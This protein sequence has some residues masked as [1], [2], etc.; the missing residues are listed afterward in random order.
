MEGSLSR[1]LAILAHPDDELFCSTLLSRCRK[2]GAE[3]QLV[4]ATRG[5]AGFARQSIGGDRRAFANVRE[6]EAKD[7]CRLLGASYR[8]LGLADGR[9]DTQSAQA[10]SLLKGIV[11]QVAPKLVLSFGQDGAYGHRDHV[12]CYRLAKALCPSGARF[13]SMQFPRGV[14]SGL[15]K[16]LSR[17]DFIDDSHDSAALGCAVGA[18]D[19]ELRLSPAEVEAKRELIAVHRSQ[20]DDDDTQPPNPHSFLLPNIAS[21]MQKRELYR[22][23]CGPALPKSAARGAGL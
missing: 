15:Y 6:S 8:Q 14:M 21:A 3:L 16:R 18:C 13:L 11:E 20:L 23:E 12:A 5:E 1:V 10:E 17:F 4:Y 19:L 2:I 7:A 22:L 9:M